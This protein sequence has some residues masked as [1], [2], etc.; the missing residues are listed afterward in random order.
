MCLHLP[1]PPEADNVRRDGQLEP[2]GAEAEEHLVHAALAVRGLPPL[3]IRRDQGYIGVLVD[4]LIDR[5]TQEPYRMFTSR[6]E[7]RLHLRADNADQRLTPRG[8]TAGLIGAPRAA[9]FQMKMTALEI[10]RAQLNAL[11]MTPSALKARGVNINQDG[12]RRSA[13]EI[14]AYP[15]VNFTRLSQLWP[16][17]ARISAPIKMQLEIEATYKGYMERQEADIRAFRRDAALII[18]D[19]LNYDYIPGLSSEARAKLMAARPATIGAAVRISGVTRAA[20]TVL[21]G[22][23]RRQT[24]DAKRLSA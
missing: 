10:G 16:E 3:H 1:C 14:L 15:D 9:A 21:L 19:D 23:V 7:Y 8:V 20:A 24:K 4:D 13:F 6:A 5:G 11:A 18:P 12:V 2:P 17:L 22:Y